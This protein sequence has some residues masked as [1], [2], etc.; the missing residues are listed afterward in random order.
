M[1]VERT[2]PWNMKGKAHGSELVTISPPQHSKHA[3]SDE[4]CCEQ[5]EP[6]GSLGVETWKVSDL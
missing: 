2:S 5:S 3:C 1:H 6:S 4:V